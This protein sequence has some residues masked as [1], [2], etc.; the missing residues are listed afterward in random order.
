MIESTDLDAA[1]HGPRGRCVCNGRQ[2]RPRYQGC[3]KLCDSACHGHSGTLAYQRWQHCLRD[4]NLFT[5]KKPLY[6]ES[7]GNVESCR[8]QDME[9]I[10]MDDGA[11][12]TTLE[13]SVAFP[14]GQ[15]RQQLILNLVS[16][17]LGCRVPQ[18]Y[19]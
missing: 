8:L 12:G 16:L 6:N 14:R 15:Q 4:A 1:E 3:G 5:H 11:K 13:H 7:C 10:I 17:D 9:R 2:L 19:C 18:K